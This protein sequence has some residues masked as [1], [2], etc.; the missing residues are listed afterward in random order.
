MKRFALLALVVA[1]GGTPSKAAAPQEPA[2]V[3]QAPEPAPPPPAPHAPPVAT[4][5]PRNDLI[6][7]SVVFG[8]PERANVQISHD[9]K[10]LSWVAAKDGVLNVWVAPIDKLDAAKPIT[11]DP[12]RPVR[13][14]FWSFD[15]KHVLYLQ[16]TAGDE[17]WHVFRADLDG[18]TADLT[19]FKGARTEVLGL[20]EKKPNQIVVGINDRDPQVMD[21]YALDITTGNRTL[22]YQND[23][24]YISFN[25]DPDLGLVFAE[26]LGPD[27]SGQVFQRDGKTWKPYD[28]IPFE[29]AQSTGIAAVAPG[30]RIAWANESRGR[31]TAAF[32][33]VDIKT[34]KEKVLAEDAR[35]DVGDVMFHPTK[36]TP[37]AVSFD[38]DREHWRALDKSIQ[39]DLDG[40]AKLAEGADFSVASMSLD[41]KTWVV[42]TTSPQHPGHYFLWDHAKH[43][44]KF[45]FASRPE[46]EKQPLVTEEAVTITARD[47]LPLVAYLT[48]PAGASGPVP[49]VM[50]VH[51]GPWA[52]DSYGYSPVVQLLANRGYA[53]LQVNYR[54][55]TG[56]GKKFLN[57]A[58]LQWAKAMHDDVLDAVKWAIDR[59]VTTKDRVA[60]AGGSY[61]GY[62]TLVG[63]AMT[64]DVFAC[65]VDLVGPSNLLTLIAS[66]PPY[67]KPL[68]ADFKKRI[69]DWETPEGKTLLEQASPLTHAADIKRPLLIGQG[70]NDP[71]VKQAEAEQIVAAM[72][73]HGLPVSYIVFPDEGHGFARPENNIAFFGAA[74][75]FLSAHLGGFYLPLSADEVKASS[76]QVKDGREGIPGLP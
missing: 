27:G 40:L 28:T 47:G 56:F 46:L 22:V 9:G 33:E 38:Y 3:A 52:R 59:G 43:A 35:A 66:V 72:K 50:F 16:D 41:A 54:G 70:A 17:N 61:G 45:L 8:N 55:S 6:P 63:L 14:Y 12:T 57:A 53:V 42:A 73:S 64:P 1:C 68:L 48:K 4:G 29:D 21:V 10:H 20:S 51:G 32:V 65:G 39:P 58:N 23:E 62:E 34:K 30:D 11:S 24:A 76:M 2:R 15:N 26:K 75:A 19:P 69:G 74:E 18:K 60:I 67:W 36:H 7:R 13:Q 71:R 37:L 44:G 25:F 5:K 49:L 31:D